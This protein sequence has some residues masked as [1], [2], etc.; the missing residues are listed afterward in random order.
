VYGRNTSLTLSGNRLVGNVCGS[1]S[2]AG[3]GASLS[4]AG[5]GA[6]HVDGNVFAANQCFIGSA[7]DVAGGGSLTTV[8]KNRFVGQTQHGSVGS[9]VHFPTLGT[10]SNNE[11][12][13]N[14]VNRELQVSANGPGLVVANNTL[15]GDGTQ[16][17]LRAF[18][19]SPYNAVNNILTAFVVG[20]NEL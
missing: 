18:G 20:M 11:F 4:V 13:G 14:A 10:I 16:D 6:V 9:P 19:T 7:L 8:G 1:G 2:G 5:G 17:G 12:I 15:K 3:G